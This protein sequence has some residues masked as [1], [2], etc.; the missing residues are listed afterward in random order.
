M[1]YRE[2]VL[3]EN[4]EKKNGNGG[5]VYV[6]IVLFPKCAQVIPIT[7]L[8]LVDDRHVLLYAK[9]WRI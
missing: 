3:I 9:L 7:I 1:V 4:R 5:E 8:K 2:G 6:R